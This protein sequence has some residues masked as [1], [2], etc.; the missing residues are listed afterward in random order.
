MTI[1]PTGEMIHIREK[2]SISS[3][4]Y[5]LKT[6]PRGELEEIRKKAA[7]EALAPG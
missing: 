6:S 3:L 7:A 2:S 4:K 1:G 5:S